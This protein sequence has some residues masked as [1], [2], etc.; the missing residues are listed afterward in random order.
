MISREKDGTLIGKIASGGF[1]AYEPENDFSKIKKSWDSM[2]ET[3]QFEKISWADDK[4]SYKNWRGWS[5]LE[6]GK[7]A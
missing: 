1:T 2:N 5:A 6:C 4:S 3:S 7:K